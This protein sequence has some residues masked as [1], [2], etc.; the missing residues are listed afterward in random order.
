MRISK[1]VLAA[2]M[3][4]SASF[5]KAQVEQIDLEQTKGVFTNTSLDLAAGDYQFNISN[6]N[7]GHDVGFV[8]VP[9]GKYDQA[10][11]IKEAYVKSPVATGSSS[12]TSVVNLEAGEYEYF[13]PLNKTPKYTLTVHEGVEEIRLGQIPGKFKVEALTVSQGLYQFEIANNGVQNEVGFVLVPKGMYDQSNHIK[14]AYVKQ[15]V[16]NGSSSSTGIV[17]LQPGEYEYFC[18]LNKT[19]KYTLT[20]TE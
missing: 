7:V 10:N 5:I 11:H 8:L 17:D 19:P 13:C 4:F 14:E 1:L 15:T 9:K 2:L 3:I 6:N 16:T 12:M 20:V 18:P